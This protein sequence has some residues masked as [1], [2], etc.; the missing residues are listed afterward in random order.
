MEE[1]TIITLNNRDYYNNRKSLLVQDLPEY[2]HDDKYIYKCGRTNDMAGRLY[3]HDYDYKKFSDEIIVRSKNIEII[4]EEDLSKAE[5]KLLDY[6][7]EQK[8]HLGKECFVNNLKK[9]P[10][11][12]LALDNH[13]L[14]NVMRKMDELNDL[15]GIRSKQEMRREF[16]HII[17]A[18]LAKH[19]LKIR[20]EEQQKYEEKFEKY[21]EERREERQRHADERQKLLSMI[22]KFTNIHM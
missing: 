14:K 1:N 21:E 20:K 10:H 19:E 9:I 4:E 12:L 7:K 22:E 17:K 18:E 8:Y 15:F 16:Q 3:G 2:I 11:E 6:C 5:T 13:E